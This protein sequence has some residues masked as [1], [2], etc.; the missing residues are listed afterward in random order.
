[1]PEPIELFFWATPN[2]YKPIIFLE[3]KEFDCNFV[4]PLDPYAWH[5]MVI[6]P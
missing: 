5:R 6:G 4:A 3:E 1:M 2:G